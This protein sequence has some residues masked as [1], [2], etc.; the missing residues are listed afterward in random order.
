MSERCAGVPDWQILI[1]TD[2]RLSRFARSRLTRVTVIR[3]PVA[4]VI[5][6]AWRVRSL[7]LVRL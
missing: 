4:P 5:A 7:Q 3:L 1:D 2:L 6:E